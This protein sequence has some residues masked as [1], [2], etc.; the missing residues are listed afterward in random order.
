[1]KTSRANLLTET[2][3]AVFRTNGRLIDW[4][5]KFVAQFGL[6]SARWQMLGALAMTKQPLTAPQLA[7]YM[8]VSRQGAQ[9]QLNL[10]VAENLLSKLPNPRHRRSPCYELTKLGIKLNTA[11]EQKWN[12]HVVK[13]CSGLDLSDIQAAIRVLMFLSEK[14]TTTSN[15]DEI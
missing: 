13:L 14:H 8:G 2:V 15:G 4:G 1:M 12:A 6:T 7:A 11:I 10:L 5:D 3:L 9:K